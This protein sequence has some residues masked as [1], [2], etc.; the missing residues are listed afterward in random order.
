[1]RARNAAREDLV[2]VLNHSAEDAVVQAEGRSVTLPAY[3]VSVLSPE[4]AAMPKLAAG[5]ERA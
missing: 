3:G 4:R 2:F 5:E 1:V